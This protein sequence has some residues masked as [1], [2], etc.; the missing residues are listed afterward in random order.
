[1]FVHRLPCAASQLKQLFGFASKQL[2]AKNLGNK[3]SAEAD[4]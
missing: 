3:K 1:M 2:Q 4:F